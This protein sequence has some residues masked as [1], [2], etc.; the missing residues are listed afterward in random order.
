MVD[1]A[2]IRYNTPTAIALFL[3]S[4]LLALPYILLGI[5]QRKRSAFFLFSLFLGVLAWLQLPFADLYRH[6]INAYRLYYDK[7]VT[8]IYVDALSAD[9]AI[10]LMSW[11]ILNNEIPYQILRLFYITES[12]FL[13]TIIFNYMVE[14]SDRIYTQG[15]VFLRF[16]ILFLFFEFVR[17]TCGVR[18]GFA[19]YQFVFALHL[20]LNKRSYFLS[21]LFAFFAIAIH[22]SFTYFVPISLA[23]YFICRTRIS[24][25]AL[26]TLG[27]LT[28]LT[29]ISKYSYLLGRRADWYFSGGTD[30]SG[31]LLASITVY[32]FILFVFVRVFLFPFVY[33]AYKHFDLFSKWSR[34][35]VVWMVLLCIFITNIT[36]FNR[37]AFVI[38][39]IGVFVLLEI[40]S[41]IEIRK[42]MIT[43]ILWCGIVTTV[44]NTVNCRTIIINSRYQY[45]A[46]PIPV[47]LQNQY[48]KQWILE[49]VDGNNMKD[50]Y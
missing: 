33:L 4:P 47:I 37:F 32:G 26:I 8:S 40:E 16:C 39:A 29:V 18:Y 6:T 20:F 19:V 30:V 3:L 35:L 22:A 17:T 7:P 25:F 34:M 46:M 43:L 2:Y 13:M 1:I 9:Y 10:P 48:E 11:F 38:S 31:N 41:K 45:I 49:H 14:R 15:E 24:S 36:M 12:F 27:L 44:F 5:Y 42:S 21:A 28:A 50:T 23:L